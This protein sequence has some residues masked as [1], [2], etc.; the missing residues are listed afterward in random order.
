MDTNTAAAEQEAL[1]DGRQAGA[2]LSSAS[3]NPHSPETVEYHQWLRG[4]REG[5]AKALAKAHPVR[6]VA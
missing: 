6:R 3:L 4:W 2:M 1:I 5:C